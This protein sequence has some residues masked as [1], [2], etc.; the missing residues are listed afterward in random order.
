MATIGGNIAANRTDSYVIPALLVLKARVV[1]FEEGEMSVDEYISGGKS[2]LIL[3]VILPELNGVSIIDRS[4]RSSAAYPTAVSAVYYSAEECI[5]ALG[6]AADRVIRLETVEEGVVSGKLKTEE[7]L[8]NAVYGAID[9]RDD[10]KETGAY[11][12]YIASTMIAR[13]VQLC[14][15]GEA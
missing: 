7:D 3:K 6:C 2:S 12:R 9:P 11:K 13:Q 14:M 10:L 8:F 1:S 4:V 5:I 15:R